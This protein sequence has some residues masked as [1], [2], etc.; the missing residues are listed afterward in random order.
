MTREH[1]EQLLSQSPF[2]PFEGRLSNGEVHQIR[3][4]ENAFLLRAELWVGDPES[5]R[6]VRRTL[7]HL[8]R[9]EE[10]RPTAEATRGNL[11]S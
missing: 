6:A 4:P 2:V 10:T 5:D 3:H 7:C 11:D 8:N 1:I 9:A